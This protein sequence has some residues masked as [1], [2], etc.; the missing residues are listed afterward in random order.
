MNRY[1]HPTLYWACNYLYM[2][3]LKLKSMLVKDNYSRTRSTPWLLITHGARPI[4][5]IS[6]EF[7]IQWNFAMPL[8]I[9]YYNEILLTSWQQYSHDACKISLWSVEHILNQ[10]TANFNRNFKFD[11]NT[12]QAPVS[13]IHQQPRYW[14]CWLNGSSSSR[15]NVYK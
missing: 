13:L 14:L 1:F 15:R 10:S 9:T 8:F 3:G 6:I 5:V 11:Q 12:G 2:L 4:N 7:R